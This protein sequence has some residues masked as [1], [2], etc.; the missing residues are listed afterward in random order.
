MVDSQLVEQGDGLNENSKRNFMRLKT[1]NVNSTFERGEISVIFNDRIVASRIEEP[2][3]EFVA[4]V[5]TS[6]I[7]RTTISLT[8]SQP[9]E[10]PTPYYLNILLRETPSNVTLINIF[11]I[12][13]NGSTK[14]IVIL[15]LFITLFRHWWTNSGLVNRV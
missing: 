12:G 10:R 14:S 7:P 1:Q 2:T 4:K 15:H 13:Y 8:N 3:K 9:V 6:E 11:H 5:F